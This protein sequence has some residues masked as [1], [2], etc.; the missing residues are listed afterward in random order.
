MDSARRHATRP[1]QMSTARTRVASLAR[2]AIVRTLRRA[3]RCPW[4]TMVAEA[5]E[6]RFRFGGVGPGA[7]DPFSPPLSVRMIDITDTEIARS[8][9]AREVFRMSSATTSH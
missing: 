9:A 8:C 1:N 7:E 2:R 5:H 3:Q 4:R 6:E